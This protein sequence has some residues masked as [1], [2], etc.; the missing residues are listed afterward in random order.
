[1]VRKIVVALAAAGAIIAGSALDASARMGGVG[2]HSMGGHSMGG[3]S[4]GSMSMGRASMGSVGFARMG[5]PGIGRA[6][7]SRVA[8]FSSRVAL[9]HPRL[10]IRDHRFRFR[11]RFFFAAAFPYGYYDGCYE[12]IWTRW[13]WRLINVC[14][15]Y[16]GY[17]PY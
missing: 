2:G 15:G 16:G 4:M 3:H 9:A 7:F 1:M 10:A 12:R 5:G 11:N 14:G 6:S 17:G 13:G 8:P